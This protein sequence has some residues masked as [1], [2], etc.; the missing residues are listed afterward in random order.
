METIGLWPEGHTPGALGS[1][2]LDIPL[3]TV[4]TPESGHNGASV[5]VCP[6]GGYH[7]LA[8]HEGEP[9]ALWLNSLGVTAF[10]L[11]YRLAPGYQHPIP[12]GDLQRAIRTVRSRA[13]DWNLDSQRIGILGFSAG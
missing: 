10:V 7:T 11:R 5:I 9:V 2:E 8:P 3:L 6:G 1:S 4:Y 13:N 12:L